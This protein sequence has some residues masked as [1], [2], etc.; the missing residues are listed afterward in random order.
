MRIWLIAKTFYYMNLHAIF[1]SQCQHD[2]SD[3]Q[4]QHYNQMEIVS[5]G[6]TPEYPKAGII[7]KI[8]MYL[9]CF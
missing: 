1:H 4:M 2:S 9:I 8:E 5:H 6:E 7:V 3:S